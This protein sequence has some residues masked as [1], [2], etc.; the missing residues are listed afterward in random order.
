MNEETTERVKDLSLPREGFARPAQ[1]AHA[2]G[3]S[4]GTLYNYIKKGK[5]PAPEKDGARIVR[6]P[7]SV[8]R[9]CLAEQGGSTL[10]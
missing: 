5:I 10:Q 6:W 4:L 8:I 3:V 1:V 2:F 9:Q 7:V